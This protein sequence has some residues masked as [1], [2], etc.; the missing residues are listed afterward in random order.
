MQPAPSSH[1]ANTTC[2]SKKVGSPFFTLK[3]N[4]CPREVPWA[5]M[6]GLFAGLRSETTVGNISHPDDCAN[7]TV[8]V[9]RR[10]FHLSA[11]VY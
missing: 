10:V 2:K 8:F 3:E 7:G 6:L 4:F 9:W 5:S 11:L 1:K